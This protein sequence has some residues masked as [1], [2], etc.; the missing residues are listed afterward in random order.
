MAVTHSVTID[1]NA[2]VE[3][4]AGYGANKVKVQMDTATFA[5][6]AYP[7]DEFG[8]KVSGTNDLVNKTLADLTK[9]TAYY[10]DIVRQLEQGDVIRNP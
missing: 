4:S 1:I 10:E 7:V 8:T 9:A 3:S 5:V 2:Y 6:R